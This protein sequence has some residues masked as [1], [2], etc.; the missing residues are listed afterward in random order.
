MVATVVFSEAE[1]C[2]QAT[3][4][5]EAV[6]AMEAEP[7]ARGVAKAE[8]GASIR[9]AVRAGAEEPAGVAVSQVEVAAK[10]VK[11]VDMAWRAVVAHILGVR[12][13]AVE[14]SWAVAMVVEVRSRA[15]E[16]EAKELVGEQAVDW[17]VAKGAQVEPVGEDCTRRAERV[18]TVGVGV[19]LAP[20]AGPAVDWVERAET[21]GGVGTLGGGEEEVV[22]GWLAVGGGSQQWVQAAAGAVGGQVARAAAV[23]AWAEEMAVA[24]AVGC[25]PLLAWAAVVAEAVGGSWGSVMVVAAGGWGAEEAVESSR[26][27]A[28]AG[29]VVEEAQV[30]RTEEVGVRL[31]DV[32]GKEAEV[33]SQQEVQEAME[34]VVGREGSAVMEAVAVAGSEVG[35]KSLPEV[36]VA[37]EAGAKVAAGWAVE[38]ETVA[39]AQAQGATK[40]RRREAL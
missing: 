3:E 29:S 13:G 39:M 37:E 1:A 23:E 9:R 28:P 32:V 15:P 25:S 35:G 22:G 11:M 19:G 24:V 27:Q 17:E 8:E 18:A 10:E 31:A 30:E 20:V 12:G 7:K 5:V 14:V 40:T 26:R 34:E 21:V 6:A 16:P 38:K 4:R 33:C 36:Q 2:T